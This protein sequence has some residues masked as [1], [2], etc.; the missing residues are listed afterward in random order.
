MQEQVLPLEL[1]LDPDAYELPA[2][3]FDR[4]SAIAKDAGYWNL[5]APAEVG[6]PG[7]DL[8]T[9]TI[10]YEE[11]AQHRSG[12][13]TPT[14]GTFGM[15]G[16]GAGL[17][18]LYEA[19]ERQKELYLYPFLNGEKRGC[20]ALTEPSGGSDPARAI[21]TKALRDGDDWLLSGSKIFISGGAVAD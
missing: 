12:L 18:Q 1:E 17:A 2:A 21:Q 11:T 20:F 19:D 10:C 5:D 13:Y 9:L 8:L 14:Y 15:H 16:A 7:L 3:D 4:L 6:G